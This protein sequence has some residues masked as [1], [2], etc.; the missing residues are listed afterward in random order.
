MITELSPQEFHKISHL[1]HADHINLEISS[2]V[3]GYSPGWIFVD[4]SES[5]QTAMV[6]SKGIEGFYF[7]GKTTSIDFN[8]SINDYI[9]HE[10]TPRANALGLSYFEFSGT[11]ADWDRLIPSLFASRQLETSKQ[12]VYTRS[13]HQHLSTFPVENQEYSIH[14]VNQALLDHPSL[15]TEY[16]KSA[17]LEWWESLD[18]FFEHGLGYGI[19]YQGTAVCSC[20][21]S[22]MDQNTMESHIQTQPAHQKKGLATWAVHAFIETA[23]TKGYSLYWDCMEKNRGSRALARKMNYVKAFDYP[24]YEFPFKKIEANNE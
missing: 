22:F 23:H 20:V 17:I 19:F 12:F 24:L 4:Q 5:P 10:I 8:A 3:E 15:N 1:L 6:W 18:H 9:A 7:L 21:T 11:S 16:I 14:V 2:V 13:A